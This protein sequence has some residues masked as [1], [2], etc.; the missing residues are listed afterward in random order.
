M[1]IIQISNEIQKK[2]N[3]LEKMRGQ[4]R[5]RAERKAKAITEFYKKKTLIIF[6]L[7]TG[8]EIEYEN[9]TIKNPTSTLIS[10]IIKGLCYKELYEM[11]ESEALYKAL[12][13]NIESVRAELNAYQ[14]INKYLDK[15]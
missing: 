4:I 10:E 2:I 15:G 6:K 5:D 8:A 3:L 12:I 1:D 14:S 11:E 7:K 13:S 9:M